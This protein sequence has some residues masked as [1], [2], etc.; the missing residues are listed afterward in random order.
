[1]A[2]FEGL[3]DF[4]LVIWRLMG[5]GLFATYFEK[6]YLVPPWDKW[7]IGASPAGVGAS[8]QQTIENNHRGDKSMIGKQALH[9][10]P[11]TF[12]NDTLPL[13]LLSADDKLDL[14]PVELVQHRGKGPI[15]AAVV[16]EAQLLMRITP[17]YHKL[18][19]AGGSAYYA[20]NATL[21]E[22]RK[23]TAKRGK[24]HGDYYDTGKLP[25]P[26]AG[27]TAEQ[28]KEHYK[29][30]HHNVLNAVIVSVTPVNERTE[31]AAWAQLALD[32]YKRVNGELLELDCS[33]LDWS[34][35]A[36]RCKHVVA[37]ASDL[38]IIDTTTLLAGAGGRRGPGRPSKK[39]GCL[40]MHTGDPRR[41]DSTAFLRSIRAERLMRYHKHYVAM[42]KD[43][44][45]TTIGWLAEMS[46]DTTPT[47]D[48]NHK[49]IMAFPDEPLGA[50]EREWT[51]VELAHGLALALELGQ[52]GLKTD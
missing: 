31:L 10:A 20:L 41:R 52:G 1:M 12:V 22:D 51:D 40:D 25:Q 13:I 19:S 37:M 15:K 17:A 32:L 21:G 38:E 14:H 26:P 27:C 45:R 8:G 46:I 3:R 4:V 36:N 49:Y 39:R 28:A 6:I 43:D 9:A 5:E 33:C 47:P 44:G 23:M 24:A 34:H 18:D 42:T 30:V 2:A 11:L 48:K 29:K 7:Y 35:S 50:R 16:A